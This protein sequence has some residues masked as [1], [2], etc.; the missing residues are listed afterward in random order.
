MRRRRRRRR[1]LP[2]PGPA[3]ALQRALAQ[4]AAPL[5]QGPRRTRC[6]TTACAARGRSPPRS[7]AGRARRAFDAWMRWIRRRTR[8]NRFRPVRRSAGSTP[9]VGGRRASWHA[10]RP[11]VTI[12]F[13]SARATARLPWGLFVDTRIEGKRQPASKFFAT[14]AE[15]E[16]QLSA[17]PPRRS[18]GDARRW[19]QE[20]RLTAALDAPGATAGAARARCCSRRLPLRWLTEHVKEMCTAATY[21]RLQADPRQPPAAQSCAPGRCTTRP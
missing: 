13:A 12:R 6:R 15:A 11:G 21:R 1:G 3:R 19:R 10:A 20:A 16:A 18:R 5:P 17:R 2:R 9:S 4:F 7:S 8:L 14:E